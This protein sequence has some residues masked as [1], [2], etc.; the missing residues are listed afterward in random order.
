MACLLESDLS[1]LLFLPTHQRRP[2][3]HGCWI[4]FRY[5]I[6]EREGWLM[7]KPI[8][9]LTGYALGAEDGEIGSVEDFLFDDNFWAVRYLVANTARWLPGRRVLISP[10]ALG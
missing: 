10:V 4:F 9:A 6:H 3:W 7:Q 2:T 1:H 5:W 8:T